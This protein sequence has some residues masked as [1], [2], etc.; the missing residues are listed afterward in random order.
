VVLDGI[1]RSLHHNGGGLTFGP[2]GML[3]VSTGDAEHPGWSQRRRSLA[4]KVLRVRP[5]G[6]VPRD[7]PFANPVWS[8]GHRNVEGIAF[9]GGGRLWATEFGNSRADEL[10]R[11][12]PGRN[13]GW[14]RAEGPDGPGGYR[15]PL[16]H[17]RPENC[18]P[19]GIAIVGNRAWIGALRG[20]S[21]WSVVLSGAHKG[22]RRRHLHGRFGR[23]RGVHAAPDGSLWITTSNRDG[24]APAH[25]H[26]DKV[27]RIRL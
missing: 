3:Y 7:N 2:D 8:Y 27:V 24:R 9:D 19:G 23:I 5:G 21:L 26:D 25:A 15:D 6:G 4:G 17:W 12:L 18:S 13:Y 16:A 10:N 14:P 20:Q 1:P 11:I 22:R